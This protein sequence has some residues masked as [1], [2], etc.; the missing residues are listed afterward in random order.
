M[1]AASPVRELQPWAIPRPVLR[2]SVLVT[3]A[4]LIPLVG[5]YLA[6]GAGA[7][8]A[9]SLG[10]TAA[11][12]PART[13][14]ARYAYALTLP[15]ALTGAVAVSVNGDAFAAACFVALACLLIA[16]ANMASN[17]LMAGLP[18]VAAVLAAAPLEVDPVQAAAWM[19]VGGVAVVTL[20]S[21]LPHRDDPVAGLDPWSAW[22]HAAAMA[23]VVGLVVGL[24]SA[25]DIPHGYWVAA[26]M[27]VV[28]RPQR[29]ETAIAARQRVVGTT[30]GAGLALVVALLVPGWI[31]LVLTAAMLVLVVANAALGRQTQQIS[32][33]TPLIVLLASGGGGATAGLAVERVLMTALGAAIAAVVALWIARLARDRA[34]AVTSRAPPGADRA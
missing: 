33:H 23:V 22:V 28:L 29:H 27:S 13:V 31:A 25:F 18:S 3:L 17:G 26:T 16:P 4:L 1:S 5:A 8:M 32:Y 15:A 30:V 10:Y 21:R 34:T 24:V 6:A 20:V 14:P 9:V 2:L 7:A 11:L 12:T 19:L